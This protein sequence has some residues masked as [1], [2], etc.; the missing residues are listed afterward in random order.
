MKPLAP[1]PF[2]TPGVFGLNKQGETTILGPEWA[3]RATDLVIDDK[4]RLANR[5]GYR[6]YSSVKTA[7]GGRTIVTQFVGINASGTKTRYCSDTS[8]RLYEL[9]G[10]TWVDRS[11]AIT[12]PSNGDWQFVNFNGKVIALHAD[13]RLVVQSAVG[14]NF[15]NIVATVGAVPTTG[16]AMLSAFGRL[17][18][19]DNTT[20]YYSGPLIETDWGSPANTMEMR[21]LW[22]KGA[23]VATGIAEFNGRLVIFGETSTV[24]LTNTWT[25]TTMGATG[26]TLEDT[27]QNI[28]C[29]NRNTIQAVGT[30]IM[31]LSHV[32]LQSLG[33]V[34][35]EKSQPV[36]DVVPQVKDYVA[37]AYASS[38]ETS[39]K[40]AYASDYGFYL[41]S[42]ANTTIC[43]DTRIKLPNGGFRV[44]EWVPMGAVWDDA[45]GGLLLSHSDEAEYYTGTYDAVA[46]DGTGGSSVEGD[47]ESGWQDWEA[48]AQGAGALNKFLKRMKVFVS[49]GSSATLQMKWYFNYGESP[50]TRSIS[51]PAAPNAAQYGVA[52]YGIDK[53]GTSLDIT[54]LS[55]PGAK[56]GRVLKVG[57]KVVG[58]TSSFALNQ[59]TLYATTGKQGH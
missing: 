13:G 35:Q 19:I 54:E 2:Y 12:L 17:W 18:I 22:P 10:S 20:I 5:G 14:A 57:L 3:T 45:N 1:F 25:V 49:G 32:G 53:Y 47:Y 7:L 26:A 4:G 42:L 27:L 51:I 36:T 46:Y 28:G 43:V 11:G 48:I 23:D 8:G 55:R 6:A 41:L 21:Y 58:S 38:V 16:K 30:D 34:I 39:V 59:M 37:S 44:T 52:Q 29:I 15:A 31:F 24:F 56:G 33:R 9:S 50:T 40:S